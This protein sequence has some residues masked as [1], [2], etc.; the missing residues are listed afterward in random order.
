M[1]QHFKYKRISTTDMLRKLDLYRN[2]IF[3]TKAVTL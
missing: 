1:L 3:K 2:Y